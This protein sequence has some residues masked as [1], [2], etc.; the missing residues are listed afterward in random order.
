[1]AP[2][3][4]MSMGAVSFLLRPTPFLQAAASDDSDDIFFFFPRELKH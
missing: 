3:L 1:M 2:R 4:M